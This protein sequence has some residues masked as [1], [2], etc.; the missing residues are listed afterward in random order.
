MAR[1]APDNLIPNCNVFIGVTFFPSIYFQ[2]DGAKYLRSIENRA[3]DIM[4]S[5][6]KWRIITT[7]LTPVF[8]YKGYTF[9]VGCFC[10]LHSHKLAR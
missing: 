8:R 9:S 10:A 6:H 5:A 3:D 4:I 1:T 7:V 2:I